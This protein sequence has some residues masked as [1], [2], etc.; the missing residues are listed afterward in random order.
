MITASNGEG[1]KGYAV[2]ATKPPNA[3]LSIITTSVLPVTNLEITAQ[4]I[5]PA[6]AAK[7]VLMYI[8]ATAVTSS[9]VPIASC[10][11]PLNP[12]HP[13][14]RINTPRVARGIE[15]FAKGSIGAA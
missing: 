11:P 13:S 10:D 5:T 1:A 6:P 8:V 7:L 14:H 4:A 3:P 15:E 12:N 9:N 2:I